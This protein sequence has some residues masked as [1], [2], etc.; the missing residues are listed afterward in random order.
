MHHHATT[1]GVE[2]DWFLYTSVQSCISMRFP[3][4]LMLASGATTWSLFS[5]D[6]LLAKRH[7]AAR[8]ANINE[9]ICG[10]F[11]DAGP[12]PERQTNVYPCDTS[13]IR[14]E[15][16]CDEGGKR[17]CLGDQLTSSTPGYLR[18]GYAP[19]AQPNE[20]KPFETT[21]NYDFP[22]ILVATDREAQ[23]EHFLLELDDE[24]LGETGGEIDG[25]TNLYGYPQATVD[26]VLRPPKASGRDIY[27]TRGFFLI[28]PGE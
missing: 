20:P 24:F 11:P 27:Y 13:F 15:F 5:D 8:Q 22:V 7:L 3:L 10:R 23:S 2:N 12:V 4:V 25:Y 18:W 6:S 28:P 1:I 9:T 14:S 16:P 19:Y 21:S 26:D 17:P